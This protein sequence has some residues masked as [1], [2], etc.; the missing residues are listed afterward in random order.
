MQA[1]QERH[2]NTLLKNEID[3]LRDENKALRDNINKP[4]CPNCGFATTGN[5]SVTVSTEDHRLR[6]QNARLKAEV[7]PESHQFSRL[8]F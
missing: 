4:S 1:I 8:M 7:N 2:E 5:D 3:K 6:V